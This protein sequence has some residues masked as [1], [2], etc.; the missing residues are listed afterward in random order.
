[1]PLLNEQRSISNLQSQSKIPLNTRQSKG[2]AL[3]KIL[4]NSNKPWYMT[5]RKSES[6]TISSL[7]IEQ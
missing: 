6:D 5:N 1:M 2:Q 7:T 3:E 4:E